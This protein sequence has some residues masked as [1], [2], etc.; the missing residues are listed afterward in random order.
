MSWGLEAHD[1]AGIQRT[2]SLREDLL[3]FEP[4]S[5]EHS[6]QNS[7]IQEFT[8]SQAVLKQ[9]IPSGRTSR[10]I[11]LALVLEPRCEFDDDA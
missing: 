4:F 10:T 6:L 3:K 8:I 5:P 7:Q 11:T 2:G 9:S 1:R